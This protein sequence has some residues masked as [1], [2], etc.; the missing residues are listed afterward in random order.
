[1]WILIL[2]EQVIAEDCG[3]L[4]S[5]T[6]IKHPDKSVETSHKQFSNM[7]K[8]RILYGWALGQVSYWKQKWLTLQPQ[9]GSKSPIHMVEHSGFLFIMSK[10]IVHTYGITVVMTGLLVKRIH[11]KIKIIVII[12][13]ITE[14]IKCVFVWIHGIS[15][16]LCCNPHSCTVKP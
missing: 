8:W 3:I 12:C 9:N 1:M 6:V 14:Q 15:V 16:C 7:C 13:K 5:K 11:S 2:F 10:C 4:I